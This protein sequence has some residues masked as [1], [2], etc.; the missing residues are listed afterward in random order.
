M[1]AEVGLLLLLPAAEKRACKAVRAKGC[2]CR[3]GRNRELIPNAVS[4]ERQHMRIARRAGPN[5][6]GQLTQI[7]DDR[8]LP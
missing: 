6:D 3:K 1:E 8:A 7:H 5:R 4:S 2:D